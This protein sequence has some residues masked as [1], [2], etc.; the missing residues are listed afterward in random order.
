MPVTVSR[1]GSSAYPG[2]FFWLV[3]LPRRRGSRAI[4]PFHGGGTTFWRGD[5][6]ACGLYDDI[7]SHTSRLGRALTAF[8]L[9]LALLP[10]TALSSRCETCPQPRAAVAHPCCHP[11]AQWSPPCCTRSEA[12]VTLPEGDAQVAPAAPASVVPPVSEVCLP[13]PIIACGRL[14]LRIEPRRTVALYTLLS[15][16]LI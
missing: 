14:A 4:P 9:A 1:L 7:M 12:P 15:I 11:S 3:S 10:A 6:P 16:L 13:S 8:L 5:R 2:A